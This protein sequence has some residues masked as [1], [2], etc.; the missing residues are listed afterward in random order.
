MITAMTAATLLATAALPMLS[1]QA[2]GDF[3]GT[4]Q[5]NVAGAG[6]IDQSGKYQCPPAHVTLDVQD[7]KFTGTL[8]RAYGDKVENGYDKNAT[9]VTGTIDNSG[10]VNLNWEKVAATGTA[11]KNHMTVAW[12]GEC[13]PRTALGEIY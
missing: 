7:G 10:V 6:K 2:K 12:Q 3:D 9:A 11:T 4:W 1:A 8:E 5:M 13:G